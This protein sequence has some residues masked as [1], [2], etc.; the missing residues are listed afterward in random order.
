MSSHHTSSRVLYG[1]PSDLSILKLT[2]A[3]CPGP[4]PPCFSAVEIF[5][6]LPHVVL[7]RN[8]S[9]CAEELSSLNRMLQKERFGKIKIL[10][11]TI[12]FSV[13]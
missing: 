6:S 13:Y 7:L 2:L 10:C 11:G 5:F 12:I 8:Q 9:S 4:L 3:I 1:C